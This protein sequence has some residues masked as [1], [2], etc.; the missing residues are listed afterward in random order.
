VQRPEKQ[1]IYNRTTNQIVSYLK[2]GVKPWVRPWNAEHAAARISRPLRHNGKPT[3][4]F[5][6][7]NFSLRELIDRLEQVGVVVKV[8][9]TQ[10]A[11]RND[12]H[13]AKVTTAP[14]LSSCEGSPA[15]PIQLNLLTTSMVAKMLSVPEGTLRYWRKVGLGP[16]WLKLEGSIRYAE[17]DVLRYI[18]RNR[19]TPSVRAYMEERN[20]I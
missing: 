19:R 18:E 7:G 13:K 12:E 5:L 10:S 8:E 2:K 16:S 15:R 20:A 14:A 4:A 11:G 1:D 6:A 17:E 3:A 9:R